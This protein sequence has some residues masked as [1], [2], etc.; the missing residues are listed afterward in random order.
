[1]Y[2][3][4]PD[5]HFVIDI[6]PRHPQVVVACGFSGHGFKFS[7]VVG[8]LLADLADEGTT[9]HPIGMFGAGRFGR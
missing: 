2:T 5:K 6:H 8:E 3:L 1:M 7:S 9:K 4:T